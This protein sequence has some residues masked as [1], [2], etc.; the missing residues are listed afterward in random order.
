[1]PG[2]GETPLTAAVTSAGVAVLARGT[3]LAAVRL[4]DGVAEE[5]LLWEAEMPSEIGADH[6]PLALQPAGGQVAVCMATIKAVSLRDAQTG[7]EI[8]RLT[9]GLDGWF[10]GVN[11]SADGSLVFVFGRW[12]RRSTKPRRAS[13]C[14]RWWTWTVSPSTTAS[15]TRPVSSSSPPAIQALRS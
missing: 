14:T 8:R 5:L 13:C 1:M 7:D 9:G 4:G 2:E 10:M 15:A 3:Q 11:Y 6:F 12:A